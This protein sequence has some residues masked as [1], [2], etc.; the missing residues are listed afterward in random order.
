MDDKRGSENN[1]CVERKTCRICGSSEFEPVI[2]LGEQY[3]ASIFVKEDFVAGKDLTYPLDVVRCSAKDGCGL[4]QLK[5]T[6]NPDVM[7]SNYGYRS[8]TN[9]IMLANLRD[10]ASK[11]ES[12]V[13]LSSGDIVLDIGCNDG[14]LLN[15][16]KTEGL[17]KVGFDPANNV[18]EAAKELGYEI[19][20]DYFSFAP[21]DRV[22]PGKKAKVV[23]SIAMFY[24]L[25]DPC[26]FVSDV[27]NLLA[28][29]GLWIIE[30]FYLQFM[31]DKTTFDTICHEHLEYYALK[32]VEWM[33]DLYDL[34]LHDIEFN[35]INGG[36]FRLFVRHK[37]FGDVPED[38]KVYLDSVREAESDAK[39]HTHE[40]YER[41]N[42]SVNKAKND[43][44]GLLGQLQEEN[45]K[46][47]VYGA[48]TKGNTLMQ[49]YGI[50][51]SIIGKAADRNPDK[52]GL[53]TPVTNIPIVSE[54]EAR[55]DKP[56]YFLVL[57]WHFLKGFVIREKDFLDDGGKFIAPLPVVSVIGANGYK[58]IIE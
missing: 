11:G 23:T 42:K 19:I 57:P 20:N 24:D 15:S 46:I 18:V 52:W 39:L 17:D 51:N 33:L 27:K 32:Q 44:M 21:F 45:K 14:T 16:Y 41:F 31:L 55:A 13:D 12:L 35:D 8:G 3:I 28:E 49:F 38:K 4:V 5:H 25:D 58:K 1:I 30:I 29:D 54:K 22:R 48:S 36:S 10:I 40:P 2:S 34:R 6:I 43:L 56:D 37:S 26:K 9:E 50:D 47:Y 7:Y 53:K